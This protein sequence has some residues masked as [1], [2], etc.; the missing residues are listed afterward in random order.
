[1]E[2]QR[3]CTNNDRPEDDGDGKGMS[4]HPQTTH[5]CVG[6]LFPLFCFRFNDV[7]PLHRRKKKDASK[8]GVDTVKEKQM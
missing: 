2:K 3:L 8:F 1:M 7:V 5:H 6:G 4:K